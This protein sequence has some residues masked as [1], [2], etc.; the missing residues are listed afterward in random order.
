MNVT[1]TSAAPTAT[2]N[3]CG[4]HDVRILFPAGVAQVHQI[5]ECTNCG[6][7]FAWPR[8]RSNISSYDYQEQQPLDWNDKQVIHTGEKLPDYS[9]IADTLREIDPTVK[10]VIEVGGYSG[11]LARHFMDKGYDVTMIE[12]DG[13]AA[14]FARLNLGVNAQKATLET[15]DLEPEAADA[16]VMLHV[17]EHVDDP[18]ATVKTIRRLLKPGGYF[19]CETPAYDSLSYQ[20]LGKR[21]RSL[22]CDGHIYFY[23]T[24]T[25]TALLKQNGFEIARV[26]KV[27]RTMSIDRMLWNF[28]IMS[29][30]KTVKD[31]VK[32]IGQSKQMRDRYLYLNL[33]DMVR[34]YARKVA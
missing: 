30:S 2:C 31:W 12:P 26:E 33:R 14:A 8:Q 34:V 20:I 17:I 4:S 23:T 13:R 21:E 10:K 1:N 7:K 28:G 27:G 9:P 16:L 19:V 3:N 29:K 32:K 11:Q 5:V 18:N 25:L 24:D 15:V 22:S 6:L